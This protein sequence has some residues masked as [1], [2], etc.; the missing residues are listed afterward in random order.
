[1]ENGYWS[2]LPPAVSPGEAE[3][4]RFGKQTASAPLE[5]QKR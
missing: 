3:S 4:R 5:M 1:M 2:F